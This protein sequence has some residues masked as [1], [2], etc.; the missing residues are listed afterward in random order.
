M[1]KKGTSASPATALA[2]RVFP[3]PGGPTSKA[4]F[5]MDAPISWYFWGLWRK[6]TISVRTSLASSSPATSANLIPVVDSTY[7]LALLF[8]NCMEGIPPPIF[9]ISL[10]EIHCPSTIKM[11]IGTTQLSRKLR[12]GDICSC[13]TLPKV[14]PDANSLSTRSGS[15]NVVVR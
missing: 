13:T 5:G 9:F 11:T 2:S 8:P 3:V 10:D 4:P 1:E 7:T 14:Q 12:I 6:S 15:S